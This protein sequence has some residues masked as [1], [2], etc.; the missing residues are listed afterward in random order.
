[1]VY[2]LNNKIFLEIFLETRYALGSVFQPFRNKAFK[3]KIEIEQ[4]KSPKWNYYSFFF[5]LFLQKPD[6]LRSLGIKRRKKF[7]TLKI[8]GGRRVQRPDDNER[9]ILR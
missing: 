5:F 8:V 7:A 1:M 3:I 9:V 4:P 2:F 6:S